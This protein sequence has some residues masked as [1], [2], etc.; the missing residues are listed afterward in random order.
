MAKGV[1]DAL[2]PWTVGAL[3]NFRGLAEGGVLGPLWDDAT[4]ARLREVQRRVDPDGMFRRA[5]WRL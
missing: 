4:F 5:G 1:V 3:P 2:A